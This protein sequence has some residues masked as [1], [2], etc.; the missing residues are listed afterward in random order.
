MNRLFYLL[1]I[2]LV[3]VGMQE[4]NATP[5]PPSPPGA[6]DKVPID[7]GLTLLLAAGAGLGIK[8]IRNKKRE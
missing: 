7:M 6:E 4:L 2:M 5:R 3:F 8:K 1:V